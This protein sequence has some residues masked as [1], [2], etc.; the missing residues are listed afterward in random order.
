[1]IDRF[2]LNDR[3]RCIFLELTGILVGIFT[4]V[5]VLVNLHSGGKVHNLESGI[6]RREAMFRTVKSKNLIFFTCS[7]TEDC[8]DRKECSCDCNRCPC[9]G[10]THSQKLDSELFESTAVEQ[11]DTGDLVCPKTCSVSESS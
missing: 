1:M 4:K 10:N 11:S 2:R 6:S 8:F 7:Q 5:R 3:N 9:C